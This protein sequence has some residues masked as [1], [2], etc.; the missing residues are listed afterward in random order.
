[1]SLSTVALLSPGDMGHA[2]GAVLVA[3]G[4]EVI[5]CLEG[6]SE[7]TKS[8]AAKAGMAAVGTYAELVQRAQMIISI[9]VPV[10]VEKAAAQ[11]ADA[12]R[13]TG[14]EIVYVDCNA[15]APETAKRVAATIEA[16]G[17][18]AVD[19]G[20]IGGP[21]GK[22]ASGTRFYCAGAHVAEFVRLNDYGLDVRAMGTEIGQASGLKMCYAALTKGTMALAFELMVAAERMGLLGAL[23][24]EWELSQA[25]RYAGLQQSLPSVPTK[26]RRWVGEMEEIAQT[27]AD[28]GLTPQIFAGAAEM[29]RWVGASALADETP[30][31]YDRDR[32]LRQVIEIL[33]RK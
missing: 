28:A 32:T 33:A 27:F 14:A 31:N 2:V 11:V 16:A 12:L 20:I 29:Y 19:A 5:T 21:P 17:S 25:A 18:R 3:N 15:V 26:A 10:E 9:M 4:L 6:R 22:D 1:M 8:L 24:A 30:E 7:R 13:E 23:V